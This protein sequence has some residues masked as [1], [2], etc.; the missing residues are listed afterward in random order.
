MREELKLWIWRNNGTV[1]RWLNL[2]LN[3]PGGDEEG[4]LWVGSFWSHKLWVKIVFCSYPRAPGGR[5]GNKPK[6]TVVFSHWEVSWMVLI[7]FHQRL[8]QKHIKCLKG[9]MS[10]GLE[11]NSGGTSLLVQV[12]SWTMDLSLGMS[13]WMYHL[14]GLRLGHWE[15][16][17]LF[18]WSNWAIT[19][20]WT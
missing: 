5:G 18:Q 6:L 10:K 16:C 20:S 3:H 15:G 11:S 4:K 8:H 17:Y 12:F 1:V 14:S 9:E 19:L 13:V 2:T 7:T